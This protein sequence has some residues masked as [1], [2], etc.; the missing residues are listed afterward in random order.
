MNH[1]RLFSFGLLVLS[2]SACNSATKVLY[3]I[4][5]QHPGFD[6][7]DVCIAYISKESK[8]SECG[9]LGEKDS[10]LW[11]GRIPYQADPK[12][13]HTKMVSFAKNAIVPNDNKCC[14]QV[15]ISYRGNVIQ[16]G[17][18]SWNKGTNYEQIIISRQNSGAYLVD[19]QGTSAQPK[20]YRELK[21]V[22]L[23][24]VTKQFLKK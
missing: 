13:A 16:L 8:G 7:L 10:L 20:N 23:D 18:G 14:L 5:H 9:K 11:S 1:S 2:F 3:L 4:Q 12:I 21:L 22:A 6:T 15:K 19:N 17:S 24:E